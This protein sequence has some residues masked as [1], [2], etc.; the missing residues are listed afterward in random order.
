MILE[1]RNRFDYHALCA[2]SAATSD[3][4]CIEFSFPLSCAGHFLFGFR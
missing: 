4:D 2:P 1:F 3:G